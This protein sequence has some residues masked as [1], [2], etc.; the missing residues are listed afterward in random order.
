MAQ[1]MGGVRQPEYVI[2]F[3]DEVHRDVVVAKAD[4]TARKIVVRNGTRAHWFSSG[5][6]IVYHM[7]LSDE[8]RSANR[9][10][11][12]KW[13]PDQNH[14]SRGAT[15]TDVFPDGTQLLVNIKDQT[16]AEK[17]CAINLQTESVSDVLTPKMLQ[18][19]SGMAI[20]SVSD[21]SWSKDGGRFASS[22]RDG[23][24]T[25]YRDN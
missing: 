4:G 25:G 12:L 21:G 14:L 10:C 16:G 6:R 22:C 2:V 7:A 11:R 17:I 24:R 9:H 19:S 13:L 3:T 15:V 20:K 1:N 18:D 8:S 23:E 5:D